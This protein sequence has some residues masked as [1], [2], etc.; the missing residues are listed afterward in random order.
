MAEKRFRLKVPAG[1]G[2][3]DP[4]LLDRA[5]DHFRDLKLTADF[6]RDADGLPIKE[7]GDIFTLVTTGER[8]RELAPRILETHYGL[9]L[10]H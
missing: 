8:A 2:Y 3:S 6:T 4:R 1:N 10:W 9:I 5:V 7:E